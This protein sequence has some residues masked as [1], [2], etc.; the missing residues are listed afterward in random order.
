MATNRGKQFEKHIQKDFEKVAGVSI[1][2]IHDQTTGFKGSTNISDFIVYKEPY[3]YYIECKTTHEKSLPFRNI[4][5]NQMKG[6][7][8][9]SKIPGVAAGVICWFI[10]CDTTIYYPI[11]LLAEMK[12]QGMKSVRYDSFVPGRI[13]LC[14]QKK[15]LFYDYDM[16]G[17]LHEL[18]W[19]FNIGHEN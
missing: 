2:R 19:R 13:Y 10:E 6:M 1:D 12:N 11:Q 15:R 7:L 9:K 3:E 4:S 8:E 16:A 5:D 17:L 18:E 14:G